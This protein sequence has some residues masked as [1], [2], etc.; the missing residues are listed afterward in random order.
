MKIK[1]ATRILSTKV[2]RDDQMAFAQE[3]IHLIPELSTRLDSSAIGLH[4]KYDKS[5]HQIVNRKLRR[6]GWT[7]KKNSY[8]KAHGEWPIDLVIANDT[9]ILRVPRDDG[10]D[11]SEYVKRVANRLFKGRFEMRD[12]TA[13]QI[14]EFNDKNQADKEFNKQ[15]SAYKSKG[16]RVFNTGEIGSKYISPYGGMDKGIYYDLRKGD[17]SL[18]IRNTH[19]RNYA[20]SIRLDY[21]PRRTR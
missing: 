21:V 16:Y 2:S 9:Y 5:I 19:D 14:H 8:V 17:L 18:H 12:S 11:P 3:L 4:F 6:L 10:V 1:A 20:V 7:L 15:L 13:F